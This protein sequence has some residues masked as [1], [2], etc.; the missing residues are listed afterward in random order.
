MGAL[1]QAAIPR[2]AHHYA[3]RNRGAFWSLLLKF[4]ATGAVLCTSGVILSLLFGRQILSVVYTPDYASYR[5]LLVWM[6]LAVAIAFVGHF[7]PA[8]VVMRRFKTFLGV[9]TLCLVVLVAL[10]SCWIATYGLI[11]AAWAILVANVARVVVVAFSVRYYATR[12]FVR[13][14]PACQDRRVSG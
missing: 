14:T 11:G 5:D 1:E 7:H 4:S 13:P 8:L 6:V 2:L 9:W 12:C 3:E 10:G